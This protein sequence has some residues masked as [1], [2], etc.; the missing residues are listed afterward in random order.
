MKRSEALKVIGKLL[1]F[2]L[3]GMPKEKIES[4]KNTAFADIIL[5]ELELLGMRPPT[6]YN[7]K[8]GNTYNHWELETTYDIDEMII[9]FNRFVGKTIR[10]TKSSG[11][12]NMISVGDTFVGIMTIAECSDGFSVRISGGNGVITSAVQSIV[13]ETDN[14]LRFQTRNS[15]YKLGV[16]E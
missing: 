5:T 14:T 1:M 3:E 4:Y 8:D 13:D 6:Y 10:L 11:R 15:I 2:G 9:K 12:E 7:Q 16:L